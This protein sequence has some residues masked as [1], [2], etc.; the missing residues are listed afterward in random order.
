M[1][2]VG[3]YIETLDGEVK[4]TNGELATL[5]R[6]AGREAVGILIG[7]DAGA[8]AHK[9]GAYGVARVLHVAGEPVEDFHPEVFAMQLATVVRDE[10][11]TDIVATNSAQGKDLMPRVAAK[12]DAP[13]ASDC[14][15]IDIDAQEAIQPVYSGKVNAR[16]KLH[17]DMRLYAV[18]P[19]A[20]AAETCNGGVAEVTMM[21]ATQES[22]R[23]EIR[24]VAESVVKQVDLTEAQAIV[25]GGY[26]VGSAEDFQV[27]RDLADVLGAAVGASRRAVD[28]G[29]APYEMQVGQ[30]GKVV[31]PQ[32]YIACGI[33]GAVQHFA[34]MK[35]SKVIVAI[36]KDPDALIF[37]KAHYGI[38]GDLFEVVPLLTKEFQQAFGK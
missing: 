17:G 32:L 16:L 12:L 4:S 10:N 24:E 22:T 8:A 30:T 34:G 18:R 6:K 14:V 33:S 9:L 23:T 2:A 1:S 29:M 31:N 21:L 20:I 38:V 36:N 35:S 28:E 19:N 11:L 27:L 26:G 25:S 5:V 7:G 13:L 37:K 3:I 15:A